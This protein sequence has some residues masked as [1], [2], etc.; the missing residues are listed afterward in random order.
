MDVAPRRVIVE[1]PGRPYTIHIG[2]QALAGAGEMVPP[3]RAGQA[4]AVLADETTGG[5]FGEEL[6]AGLRAGGWRPDLVT[7]P[8]GESSKTLA[9]AGELCGRLADLGLDRGSAVF[10]LGGGVVGDLGGFVAAT[11]MRGIDFVTVPTTLLAQ[12]DSSVGG[13]VGVDLPQAKNLVGAF[14]QP[15]AVLIDPGTLAS[16]PERQFAA[17][18]AEVVKHAAIAD[19]GLFDELGRS[20][21]GVLAR[22]PERLAEIVARNCEIK[23]SVVTRDPE[24]RTGLRAVLNYGHTIGHAVE[25]G[26]A[27]WGL[28]HG[29]AVAVGMVVESRVAARRG[30]SQE[31]VPRRLKALLEALRVPTTVERTGIDLALAVRALRADKKIVG[32]ALLLP[33]APTLGRA[34]LTSAVSVDDLASEMEDLLL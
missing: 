8:P 16:L 19:A 10:A 25:R 17:G 21:D 6:L 31:A 2:P 27:A 18:L 9:M 20:A 3:Y 15:R 30:L 4:A 28:L 24:E 7:I 11:Y 12:V 34:E 22:E 26:A 14:H 29:E 23:A 32:G 33:V 13:K 1:L 5:L